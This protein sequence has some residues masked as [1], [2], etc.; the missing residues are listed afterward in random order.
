MK[1]MPNNPIGIFD[2]GAGG[3]SVWKEIDSLLPDESIVYYADNANCP[4][5]NKTREEVIGHSVKAAQFLA[6]RRCKIIV[7]AC[8]TATSLAIDCL[9]ET[10]D[11]PFV[12]I[13]PAVKPA[14]LNSKTGVI[15]ILA[16]AGTLKSGKF[17]DAKREFSG[18]TVIIPVESGELVSIVENGL[19]G[20]EQ[21]DEV[22][23]KY[24]NPLL[25]QHIDHL[26]LGCTHFPFLISDIK[27][28]TGDS[29]ILDNPAPAIAKRTKYIL[30][31][32]KLTALSGNEKQA[33]F[34]SSGNIATLKRMVES[35]TGIKPWMR[36][37]ETGRY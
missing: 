18:N 32:E 29:V 31:S 21:S 10:F 26:V 19:Q 2:S 23:R 8:N 33:E 7:I 22:L 15:A 3:L 16:T 14:A 25:L 9:R 27:R 37:S 35:I 4:Y 5:G 24:I 36:F 12:G 17:A 13:V 1:K 11:I 34:F 6:D 28:I 20:T 30:E